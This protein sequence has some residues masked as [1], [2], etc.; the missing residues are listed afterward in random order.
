MLKLISTELTE[1]TT[2]LTYTDGLPVDNAKEMLTV[3]LSF[4]GNSKHSLLWVQMNAMAHVREWADT[5][6]RRLRD[7]SETI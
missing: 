7:I 3:R 1:E 6:Y 2:Q 5:E 4:D